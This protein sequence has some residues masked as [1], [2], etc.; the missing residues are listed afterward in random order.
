M[1]VARVGPRRAATAPITGKLTTLLEQIRERQEQVINDINPD[2]LTASDW[3]QDAEAKRAALIDG[4]RAWLQSHRDDITAL[5]IFF[6][7]P[8]RR[9]ELTAH[10]IR[11]LLEALKRERPAL[12]PAR[13]WEAYV[14]LDEVRASRPESELAQSVALV[15]QVCGWDEK[16]TPYNDTVRANFKRWVGG[17]AG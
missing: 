14:R 11:E 5:T 2:T 17:R 10:L 13:V 9:K 8:Y 7:Q 6:G 15:R 1:N 3:G 12:A 4:F 16:L